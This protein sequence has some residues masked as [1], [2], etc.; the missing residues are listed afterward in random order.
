M[1]NITIQKVCLIQLHDSQVRAT[2]N[3]GMVTTL[4]YN[5]GEV[6]Q[7]DHKMIEMCNYPLDIIDVSQTLNAFVV[8]CCV[9]DTI[10]DGASIAVA[11]STGN[12]GNYTVVG[13]PTCDG[14]TTII[15][16]EEDIPS[17]VADGTIAL[18]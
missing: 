10:E 9:K 8:A 12:D 7:A 6:N 17:D 5:F 11:D 14:D 16:V 3:S 4:Q 13:T 1:D 2:T 15:I 18:T